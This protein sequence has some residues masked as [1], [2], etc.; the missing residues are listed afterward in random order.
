MR[1]AFGIEH[2]ISKKLPSY[3]RSGYVWPK[4]NYSHALRGAWS[5]GNAK[6]R[7]KFVTLKDV[8]LPRWGRQ[9]QLDITRK[10]QMKAQI[11]SRPGKLRPLKDL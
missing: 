1:S 11:A 5:G 8:D 7:R 10:K 6:N 9:W 4:T 2:G 3:L